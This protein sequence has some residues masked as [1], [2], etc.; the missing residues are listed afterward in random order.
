MKTKQRQKV[1]PEG[2]RN[3]SPSMNSANSLNVSG[4]QMIEGQDM[5]AEEEQ[6]E[7]LCSKK[8]KYSQ[9]LH[10]CMSF[11][12]SSQTGLLTVVEGV[13]RLCT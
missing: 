13:D 1:T 11:R 9:K 10:C 8:H 7:T 4:D 3:T 6:T 2:K 12:A 5:N